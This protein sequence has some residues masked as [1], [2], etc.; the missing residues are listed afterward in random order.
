[1]NPSAN[2]MAV[3]T[4]RE[5]GS[6]YLLA[7]RLILTTAHILG[8][9]EPVYVSTPGG[10]GVVSCRV[11]WL[12]SKGSG[13]EDTALLQAAGDLVA[14]EDAA[15]FKPIHWGRTTNDA[16][17]DGCH[18]TGFAVSARSGRRLDSVQVSGTFLP[19]TAVLAGRYVLA[20][21]HRAPADIAGAASPWSGMS[22]AAL[23][24]RDFLMGVVVADHKPAVYGHSRIEAVPVSALLADRGFREALEEY[25]PEAPA[26]ATDVASD[27]AFDPRF[28]QEYAEAVRA[29][30]GRIR[31]FGLKQAHSQ[32]RRGWELDAAYLSLEAQ[33]A[34]A[35]GA[36]FR[37]AE[38]GTRPAP[39]RVEQLL[40]GRRRV[41]LRGEAGS[42]K[43]TLVQWLA[44][45]SLAGTLGEELEY[46]N[47]RVPLVLQLRKLF[48]KGNLRPRP[49]EFLDLDDRMCAERQPPGWAH[50][51]L[52]SGRA[53]L[54]VDGLD[55]VP[56][57]QRDEALDWLE[58][59][60]GHY[61][62]VWT[63]ATVRPSAV[64]PGWLDHFGFEELSLCPMGVKDRGLFIERWHEAALQEMLTGD[65]TPAE[66]L[67]WRREIAE[68]RADLLRALET[69]P[70]LN[71]LT[72]SPLL[73]AMICALNRESDGVLPRRRMEIY[74]DAL[75]MMLVKRD[76]ARRLRGPEQMQLSEEEQ[77][78]MLRRVA[79]WLVLN[80]QVEG[81]RTDAVAQIAKVLW[82]LPNVARQGDA[83]QAY[84]HLL[85]RSGL[86][87]ETSAETFQFVHRTFQD[88]LAAMEFKEERHFGLLA[89][90]AVEEQWGDVIRLTAGHCGRLDRAELLGRILAEGDAASGDRQLVI[91]LLAG[92]CL[93]YA[94]ELAQ[95]VR[96]AVLSRL[97]GYLKDLLGEGG[98][99][100][101]E[102]AAVGED[103]IPMLCDSVPGLGD[104]AHAVPGL[105]GWIGGERALDALVEL[106][107]LHRELLA[108][109]ILE[110]WPY[111]DEH[112]FA[113][114]VLTRIDLS[115]TQVIVRSSA[116]L[117]ELMSV[118]RENPQGVQS[119]S[120]TRNVLASAVVD[121]ALVGIEELNDVSYLRDWPELRCLRLFSCPNITSLEPLR[122]MPLTKLWVSDMPG[123]KSGT[124]LLGLLGELPELIA[125]RATASDLAGIT[126][127]EV[128]PGVRELVVI[129]VVD[130]YPLGRLLDVFPGVE[131]L[132]LHA[133]GSGCSEIDLRAFSGRSRLRVDVRRHSSVKV[134]GQD[135]FPPERLR[136]IS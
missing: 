89:G 4:A 34:D 30:Y 29:D 79:H 63:I 22:G 107:D 55:E 12:A 104:S 66:E 84:T 41:L 123:L 95:E 15:G 70:E 109:S 94:P 106:A 110:Q 111:I 20:D 93:P 134:L 26:E 17:L 28:E 118:P 100:L 10:R 130:R 122:G 27:S 36:H 2:R 120:S 133:A 87:T 81:R 52:R 119:D 54:L 76:E 38:A 31:I 6:G 129:D 33:Q 16:P 86:I 68:D 43:T 102:L 96:D 47:H 126:A 19:G 115:K 7:P 48:R 114:R 127:S 113:R 74:R 92:S 124:G 101:S 58:Q 3:V 78:A 51:V 35:A 125:L 53:M 82:D 23:F 77:L 1:M 40:K 75:T 108:Q 56:T 67:R 45:R 42:G 71:Q 135:L 61:P 131:R 85:N 25:F 112:R 136:V 50:R 116:Q 97:K 103:L 65:H 105:L 128:V 18:A 69:S 99:Y 57:A 98:R 13:A 5:Q 24:Y 121:L 73:C 60:L 62:K 80:N 46:L 72:D 39:Q 14:P 88:Y 37:T 91:Y 83:D 90:R 49:E 117:A 44:V 64:P 59:L 9:D 21:D 32:G 132:D 8:G 11:L